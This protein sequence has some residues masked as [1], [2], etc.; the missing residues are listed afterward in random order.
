[1][2]SI[3]WMDQFINEV[4]SNINKLKTVLLKCGYAR[5]SENLDMNT[6]KMHYII[7]ML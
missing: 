5:S 3:K 7:G 1:M 4:K 2:K 6:I